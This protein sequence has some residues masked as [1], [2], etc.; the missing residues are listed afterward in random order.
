MLL[1]DLW[2]GFPSPLLT[3]LLWPIAVPL[4][5]AAQQDDG[6]D[7]SCE[8][9][10][11]PPDPLL[12]LSASECA[13][14]I[15]KGDTTSVALLKACLAQLDAVNPMLNA[16]VADRRAEVTLLSDCSCC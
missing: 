14:A 8:Q 4:M 9:V 13:A 7:L 1:N 6:A 2:L 15:R 12:F 11:A 16:C 3:W 10:D 5:L